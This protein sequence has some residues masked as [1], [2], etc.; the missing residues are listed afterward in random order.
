[1]RYVL[2]PTNTLLIRGPATIE[3]LEGHASILAAP[4]QPNRRTL[5]VNQK[6]LPIEA[7]SETVLEINL[8]KPE[9]FFEIEGSTIPPSWKIAADALL[10]I[11]EGKVMVI[12]ATDVGKSTLCVY[13][14]NQLIAHGCSVRV[15]DADIGQTD[16]GP[17][18]TIGNALPRR[19]I[20]SLSDLTPAATLFIGHTSPNR[21][22][23]K[24]IDG[25]Q[26]LSNDR[27]GTVTI[28][29]TDGWVSE[30]D[31]ILFKTRMIASLKPNF[32][33]G[34][35]KGNELQPILVSSRA[36]SMN[37]DAAKQVLARSRSNR[38]EIRTAGYR[39]SLEGARVRSIPLRDTQLS[40][41]NGFPSLRGP[42]AEELNDLI[43][44]LT[45]ENRHLIQI[46]IFRGVEGDVARVYCRETVNLR[47]L[48]FGYVR[49]STS[50]SEIGYFEP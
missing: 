41:P 19:P 18:T 13:L 27:E 50:G 22:E 33:L 30:P 31:A 11:K 48:E 9:R 6:Q 35:A 16:L 44:G 28:V 29:N 38:R 34:L 32:V 4:L 20:T 1:M 46:G 3:L 43:V 2:A 17:P 42:R 10:D 15:V 23:S 40:I 47:K 36:E 5:I 12:G 7:E 21:V 49:L 26:E 37:V 39:R 45:E 24:L 25:V 8:R 14:T